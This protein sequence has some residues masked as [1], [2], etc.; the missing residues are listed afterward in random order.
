MAERKMLLDVIL[1][2]IFDDEEKKNIIKNEFKWKMRWSAITLITIVILYI[3]YLI[4]GDI[5]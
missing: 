3:V 4:W 5:F 2:K 1:D